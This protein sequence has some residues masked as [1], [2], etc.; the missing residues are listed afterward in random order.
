MCKETSF[1]NT[2]FKNSKVLCSFSVMMTIKVFG[3]RQN[4]WNLFC[5]ATL[6]YFSVI[7]Y[8][9][10]RE[11]TNLHLHSEIIQIERQNRQYYNINLGKGAASLKS[12]EK[13]TT[14]SDDIDF[15]AMSSEKVGQIDLC[16][17]V[18]FVVIQDQGL[19]S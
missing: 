8:L 2:S 9:H 4:L 14:T 3:M 1:L 11:A 16:S 5:F 15:K 13:R 17:N 7:I 6:V 12:V 19:Q 18:G 10:D